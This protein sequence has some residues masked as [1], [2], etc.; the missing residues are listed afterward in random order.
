MHRYIHTHRH[1]HVTSDAR[2]GSMLVDCDRVP[3]FTSAG[4]D[5]LELAFVSLCA[6]ACLF[7]TRATTAQPCAPAP[8]PSSPPAPST[9]AAP[10]A[11]SSSPSL[12]RSPP[13]LL[14]HPAAHTSP[15]QINAACSGVS[16]SE[17]TVAA[18]ICALASVPCVWLQAHAHDLCDAL[19]DAGSR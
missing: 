6:Q 10:G 1:H 8:S 17:R 9:R 16:A 2:S 5:K 4:D 14:P 19:R 3:L 12:P 15:S 11:S 7:V 13:P 18:A